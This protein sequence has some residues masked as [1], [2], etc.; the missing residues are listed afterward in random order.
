MPVAA[1]SVLCLGGS[2]VGVP[3]YRAMVLEHLRR[4]GHVF[5]HVEFVKDAAEAGAVRLAA[6]F[7]SEAAHVSA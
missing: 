6:M 5:P 1:S 2:L 7:A 3:A 4:M